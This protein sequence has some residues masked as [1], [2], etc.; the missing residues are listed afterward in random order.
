[1]IVMGVMVGVDNE[2]SHCRT[3]MSRDGLDEENKPLQNQFSDRGPCLFQLTT[4]T[5]V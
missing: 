3:V 2:G 4:L 5:I 1:M